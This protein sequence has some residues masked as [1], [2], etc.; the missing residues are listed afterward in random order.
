M[1]MAASSS[2]G[3]VSRIN[4]PT[5]VHLPSGNVASALKIQNVRL[6]SSAAAAPAPS[7][8][9]RFDVV[10]ESSNRVTDF[11]LEISILEKPRATGAPIRPRVLV[12]PFTIQ[13]AVVL[14]SGYTMNYEMVL[15]N[16]SSDCSCRVIVE[17]LSARP[18]TNSGV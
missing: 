17:V 3:A 11:V 14:E 9:L 2:A 18:V 6:D 16:L 4:V 10:N 15:R 13:G 7:A 12:R 8:I 1:S 5:R